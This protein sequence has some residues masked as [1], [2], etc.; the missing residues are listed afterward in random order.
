[1]FCKRWTISSPLFFDTYTTGIDIYVMMY[2]QGDLFCYRHIHGRWKQH[3]FANLVIHDHHRKSPCT[4]SLFIEEK[5]HL[6]NESLLLV[7]TRMVLVVTLHEYNAVTDVNRYLLA[8]NS[9]LRENQQS[10]RSYSSRR[11][12]YTRPET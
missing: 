11:A 9:R 8:G 7:G 5:T 12:R 6:N 1:M 4:L 2:S 10:I 3:P